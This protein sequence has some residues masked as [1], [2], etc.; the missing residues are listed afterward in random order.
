MLIP[1]E[2]LTPCSRRS[3]EKIWTAV[4]EACSVYLIPRHT[5]TAQFTVTYY[6]I[7]LLVTSCDPT[8]YY[9]THYCRGHH[10]NRSHTHEHIQSQIPSTTLNASPSPSSNKYC[11]VLR[12]GIAG[13]FFLLSTCR[14]HSG[15]FYSVPSDSTPG[16]VSL[17]QRLQ[18]PLPVSL[19]LHLQTPLPG[20]FI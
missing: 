11:R 15:F 20:W 18:I 5:S 2:F 7:P 16:L 6:R 13:A 9:Y 1:A 12:S 4:L 8:E 10:R 17:T 19:T 3:L 14:F